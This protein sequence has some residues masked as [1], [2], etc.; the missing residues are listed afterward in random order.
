MWG[1]SYGTKARLSL[2]VKEFDVVN[3][4]FLHEALS[5]EALKGALLKQ[6]LFSFVSF[7]LRFGVNVSLFFFFS[8]TC[9]F[10]F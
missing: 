4:G 1:I 5:Y 2:H 10:F 3:V 6:T 8:F 9:N 7:F